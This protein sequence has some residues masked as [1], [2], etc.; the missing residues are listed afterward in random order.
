MKIAI[1]NDM[2]L[3]A[4][5]L[6]RVLA[7]S[8]EHQLVW[9]AKD[10][11]EAVEL[12]AKHTPDLVLMDLIMPGMNGVE[13]T[14]R[15]MSGSPCA[16][17]IVTVSVENNTSRVFEAM[18]YGALDAVDIPSLACADLAASAAPLLMKIAT[19]GRLL[20]DGIGPRSAVKPSRGAATSRQTLV[21]IG[22]SA[23]GPAAIAKVLGGL[24]RN[25]QAAIVIVQHI[26]EQ[27]SP[28]M[29]RWLSQHSALP[30]RLAKEGDQPLQGSVLLAGSGDHLVLKAA[31]R[32]GYTPEPRDYAYRPSVDALF[33]SVCSLWPGRAIGVLLTGM[34]R[35]GALGL[36]ALRAKGHYT[37]AQDQASSAVYGMPKAAAAANAAVDILSLKHIAP[38]LMDALGSQPLKEKAVAG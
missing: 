11:A 5:A 3:A 23:G 22:A 8:P 16:I 27:F 35:D 21:A 32:L 15:I 7:L 4:E 10:G 14:R 18:G 13:A 36:K 2:P 20:G 33:L 31:D 28:G 17:L 24:P 38:K 6:R 1:V 9:V 37:I 19:I 25:F 30:V 26:D 34:G 29:A 12:C